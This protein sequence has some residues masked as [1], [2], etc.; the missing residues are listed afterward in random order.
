MNSP[1][2]FKSLKYV[3]M[4]SYLQSVIAVYSTILAG[5][6]NAVVWDL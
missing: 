3:L 1:S 4:E 2:T 6:D 5:Q